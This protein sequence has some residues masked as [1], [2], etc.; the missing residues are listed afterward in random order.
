[1]TDNFDNISDVASTR[2]RT[3]VTELVA[4]FRPHAAVPE[5]REFLGRWTAR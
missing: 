1:M 4:D 5:V 2:L 3:A